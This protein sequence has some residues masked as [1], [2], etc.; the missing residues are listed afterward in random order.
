MS[1]YAI[2]LQVTLRE[3]FRYFPDS[4]FPIPDSRFPIPDFRF[5]ISSFPLNYPSKKILKTLDNYLSNHY[6]YIY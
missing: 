4:R 1:P 2:D 6:D 3:R 5:P